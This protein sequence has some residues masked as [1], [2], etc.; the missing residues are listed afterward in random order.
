VIDRYYANRAQYAFWDGCSTGGRQGLSEAEKYPTD[1][2]GILAGAPA[3]NWDQFMVAQMWPQLVMEWSGDELPTCKEKL[4]NA[5][6]QAQCRDQDG[7]STACST[8]GTA[9]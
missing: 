3:L 5:T 4:V 7:R 8:R 6:L 9:T 1:F 2:N